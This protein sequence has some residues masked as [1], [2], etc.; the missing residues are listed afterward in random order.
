MWPAGGP[1]CAAGLTP[2]S[3]SSCPAASATKSSS[4]R[5][6]PARRRSRRMTRRRW[7]GT[8]RHSSLSQRS[9]VSTSCSATRGADQRRGGSIGDDVDGDLRGRPDRRRHAHRLQRRPHPVHHGQPLRRLHRHRPGRVLLRRPHPCTGCHGAA[10][11]DSTTPCTV[12]AITQI[13]HRHSPG[14]GYYERKLAEGK[15]PREG[16][17]RSVPAS[18][19]VLDLR[20]RDRRRPSALSDRISAPC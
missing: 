12:A 13:R 16:G 10:T 17:R 3:P 15:T 14:R 11:A 19:R 4:T 1:S 5:H 7:S 2:S 20:R 9:T 18:W 6:D 8:V